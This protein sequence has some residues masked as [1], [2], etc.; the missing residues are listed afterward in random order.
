[1]AR[2]IDVI[3]KRFTR[4]IAVEEVPPVKGKRK[5]R[6]RCDCGNVKIV[7]M[8]KLNNGKIKSCG[9][10]MREFASRPRAKD[11]TGQVFGRLTAMHRDGDKMLGG[12]VV[13][14]CQCECG[15]T[16]SVPSHDL[17]SGNTKS[18]GCASV[19]HAKNMQSINEERHYKDGAF[20][21]LLTQ[22][23]QRNSSTGHKGVSV[24]K[25]KNGAVKYIANITV[26][27]ERIYLG[28]FDSI[29]KAI[30][31]RVAA[32]EKYHKPYLEE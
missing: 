10:Y 25:G 14:F 29:D 15:E 31:A 28:I 5:V 7:D 22:K 21:P 16:S 19:E 12:S 17:L 20:V 30:A 1:M 26:K 32:E 11:L 27:N 13:W 4:L 9:C 3:G 2:R 24:R 18:C 6:C 8:Y 23:L